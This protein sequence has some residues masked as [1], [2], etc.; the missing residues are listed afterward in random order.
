MSG[1]VTSVLIQLR[2]RL[3]ERTSD[4]WKRQSAARHDLTRQMVAADGTLGSATRKHRCC[5]AIFTAHRLRWPSRLNACGPSSRNATSP[6]SYPPRACAWR[7]SGSATT[8]AMRDSI[9]GRGRIRS[10]PTAVAPFPP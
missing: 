10:S 4:A 7:S 5:S 1:S 9:C 2:P 8:H 3:H 6:S